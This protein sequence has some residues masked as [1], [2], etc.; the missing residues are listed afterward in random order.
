[1]TTR[2]KLKEKLTMRKSLFFSL[3]TVEQFMENYE[4]DRDLA[5]VPVRL[6]LLDQLYRDFT[7]VQVDIE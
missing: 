3:D 7:K 5:Q 2:K 4:Q 6:E 1:M